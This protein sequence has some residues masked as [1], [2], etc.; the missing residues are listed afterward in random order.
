MP[1]NSYVFGLRS[2]LWPTMR[3]LVELTAGAPE[4]H[5]P[6]AVVVAASTRTL[7][8]TCPKDGYFIAVSM[9]NKSSPE[10]GKNA[11]H[12]KEIQVK[13]TPSVE[14]TSGTSGALIRSDILRHRALPADQD[15]VRVYLL[16]IYP[17]FDPCPVE[18]TLT[19]RIGEMEILQSSHPLVL[20]CHRPASS[21]CFMLRQQCRA[22]PSE[23]LSRRC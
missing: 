12:Q 5:E 23:I 22:N 16:P 11:Y 15:R 21:S 7:L 18:S 9:Y 17:L 4:V 6:S 13:E 2:A 3:P 1:R 8:R 20:M 10:S 14:N 19:G